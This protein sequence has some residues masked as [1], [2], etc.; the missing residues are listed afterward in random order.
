MASEVVEELRA[1]SDSVERELG[2]ALLKWQDGKASQGLPRSLGYEPKEI[3][4]KG[5]IAVIESRVLKGSTGFDEVFEGASYEAIVDRHPDRFREE[6]VTAARKRLHG[7]GAADLLITTEDVRHIASSRAK[8]KFAE[9]TDEEHAAYV[10][11][12]AALKSL[13]NLLKSSLSNSERFE[14]RTTS[15]FNIKSGVRSYIPKDLWFSVSPVENAADLAGMPQFFMIVSERGIEYGFGASVSPSDFSQQTVKDIVR[16]AAPI[17]FDLLPVPNSAEATDIQNDLETSG[18]WCFRRKHRLPPKQ[19]DFPAFQ[20]WLV[21]LKSPEGKKN[22]AGTI[23]RYLLPEEVDGTQLENEIV[24]MARL[25]Q[26]LIDRDW[27]SPSQFPDTANPVPIAETVDGADLNGTDEF[28]QRLSDFIGCYDAKRSGPYRV[29]AELHSAMK[30]LQEWLEHTPAVKGRPTIKVKIGVGQGK[31]TNTPWIAL[32]D[33]RETSTTQ[34][35][36]YIVFLIA[37]D[38]TITY[39]TLNQGMTELRNELSQRGA[40]EEMIRVAE[41]TRPMIPRLRDANFD[42]DN[43]IDLKS[44]TNAAKN[45]EIGTIAHVDL[46][47][48]NLPDDQTIHNYLEALLQAYDRIIASRTEEIPPMGDDVDEEEPVQP[49]LEPYSIEDALAEL[50]LEREE[51]ERYLDIWTN[52]KNLI[53][54]GAPGVGKSFIARRLAYALI[55]FKDDRKVQTVQFHQSYSYED[56]VQGYRPNGSQGF[57]RK[58]GTF[59][60]FRDRALSD[61]DG[62]Y[63]FIIDE[64]NRGNLSKI[65]GEL[66]LLIESDKRGPTW[67]TR[68]AYARDGD[69]DFY[70]PENLFILGMMNT[71][72]RSLSLVDYALRRRF[73]FVSMQPLYGSAKFREHL[74][75]RGV[76]DQIIIRVVNGMSELNQAIESDRTSLGPGFRIGH[77]FFTPTKHITDPDAWYSRIIETEIYPLL[78]EYWFDAPETA[79]QWRKKLLG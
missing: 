39:L 21:Y 33:N 19:S 47:T 36:T 52:K 49:T 32:L 63:V 15:G 2:E 72:D 71:A 22:A 7:A 45:Y 66:M 12:S 68:L 35:G 24:E 8:Q 51:V 9:I 28:S 56:F 54:Q 26:P 30:G 1:S 20:E 53:L 44:T 67:K 43:S 13:G 46:P 79:E 55:G 16:R 62:T 60:E 10:R 59:Y 25:F 58:N 57:D 37:E 5:A 11:V 50:F 17:V 73:A 41:K 4:E 42:F 6:V 40:A 78:E 48:D 31:W 34:R 29:D 23:S 38:L 74:S 65:F 27:H 61:P 14:V 18:T 3:R 76:P 69:K 64:I 70:V 77:S 75:A